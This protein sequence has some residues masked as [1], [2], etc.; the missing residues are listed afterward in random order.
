[1]FKSLSNYIV[2]LTNRFHIAVPLLSNKSQMMSKF[3]KKKQVAHKLLGER[4]T[5]GR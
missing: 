3:G 1:M 4:V 2:N 5:E